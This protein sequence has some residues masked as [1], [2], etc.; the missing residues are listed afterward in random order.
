M[1]DA[2]RHPRIKL[3]TLSEVEEVSGYVGNFHVKVRKKARFV[4]EGAC[5]SCGECAE[6]CPVTVPDEYQIGLGTRKAIYKPFPQ[7]VPSAYVIN[8]A[9]CLGTHPIACGKCAEKC[10]KKCIDLDMRDE[11][12]EFD[13]GAIIVATGM[14]PYDPTAMDEY[15][16]TRFENV[17]TSMEF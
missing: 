6:V 17:I 15:G 2:G 3:L 11:I 9:N 10:Q 7:A 8:P 12:I 5:T 14:E 4:N 16:Y 1:M 13:V